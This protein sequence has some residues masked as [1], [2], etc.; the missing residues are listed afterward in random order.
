MFQGT[1]FIS[2]MHIHILYNQ[3]YWSLNT[4]VKDSELGFPA[5]PGIA[6]SMVYNW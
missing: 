1:K 5:D 4:E 6:S 3:F 2:G